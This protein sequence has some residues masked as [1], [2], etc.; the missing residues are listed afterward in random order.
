MVQGFYFN[1]G[2]EV[3]DLYLLMK[4]RDISPEQNYCLYK[5]MLLT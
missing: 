4:I 2:K 3:T 5:I 1:V